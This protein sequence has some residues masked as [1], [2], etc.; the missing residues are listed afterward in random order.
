MGWYGPQT[1]S[2]SCCAGVPC[3]CSSDPAGGFSVT[4]QNWADKDCCENCN[5]FSGTHVLTQISECY[6]R[7]N[8]GAPAPCPCGDPPAFNDHYYITMAMYDVSG[9]LFVDIWIRYC[10]ADPGG[11]GESCNTY[12]QFQKTF[13]G[14]PNCRAFLNEPIPYTSHGTATGN[15]CDYG[16][17]IDDL[18]LSA[19]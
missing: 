19:V 12:I 1:G 3:G 18:L 17:T 2:C 7:K 8:G 16:V 13:T 15:R 11:F 9:N 14:H 4:V 6:W 5:E 10:C